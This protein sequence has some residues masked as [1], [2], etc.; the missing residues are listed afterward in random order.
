M[1]DLRCKFPNGREPFALHEPFFHYAEVRTVPE[2]LNH[3]VL[4]L[5]SDTGHRHVNEF[6]GSVRALHQSRSLGQASFPLCHTDEYYMA[7]WSGKIR[8]AAQIARGEIPENVVNKE[9]LEKPELQAK[10]GRFKTA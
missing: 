8:Q 1:G 7:A 3:A 5:V 2:Y 4:T 6:L 9:V 10:L